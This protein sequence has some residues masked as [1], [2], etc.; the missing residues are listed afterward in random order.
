MDFNAKSELGES[1]ARVN[2]TEDLILRVANQ[3]GRVTGSRNAT[4]L[5]SGWVYQPKRTERSGRGDVPDTWVGKARMIAAC[6]FPREILAVALRGE[7]MLA[8]PRSSS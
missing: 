7:R 4:R 5:C 2:S 3:M 8:F 1:S 6:A